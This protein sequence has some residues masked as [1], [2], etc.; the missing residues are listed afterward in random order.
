MQK[1]IKASNLSERILLLFCHN[2]TT[3]ER[4]NDVVN[5]NIQDLSQLTRVFPDFAEQLRGKEALDF[6]CGRGEQSFAMLNNGA[7]RV[8]GVDI[9]LSG[10]QWPQEFDRSSG[11]AV[12][13]NQLE[14]GDQGRFDLVISQNSMEHFS[15]PDKILK[16]MFGALKPGGR[17]FITFGPPW[18]AP[19]GSHMKYFT[20]LPWVNILFPE[21]TVMNVRRHFRDDGA[22]RYVDVKS[23][24][25]MMSLAKFEGLLKDNSLQVEYRLYECFKK[26]NFL[27]GVPL[28]RELFVN[29]V[30]VVARKAG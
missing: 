9:D 15:D 11:K 7:S 2:P 1:T 21:K 27:G 4:K 16:I 8:T 30:S 14:A 18:Y 20:N 24:L 19:Y 28:V 23:G 12:F 29:Q 13:K 26:L 10:I 25:N 6:G 5:E 17:L 3:Y 22:T